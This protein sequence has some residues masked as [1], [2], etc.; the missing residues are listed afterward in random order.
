MLPRACEQV[1]KLPPPLQLSALNEPLRHGLGLC[2]HAL[3]HIPS[4]TIAPLRVSTETEHL[5]LFLQ[6]KE[7]TGLWYILHGLCLQLS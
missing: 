3:Y 6:T 4:P 2:T 7:A 5:Y 1:S